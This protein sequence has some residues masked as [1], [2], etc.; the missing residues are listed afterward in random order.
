MCSSD[1]V[2]SAATMGTLRDAIRAGRQVLINCAEPD[3]TASRHTIVPIS[4]AGG[5]VRGHEPASQ[6]LQSFPLHRLIAVSVLDEDPQLDD[7]PF[8]DPA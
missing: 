3:G 5:F 7:S 6:R 8:D 1:L 2:T 4:M